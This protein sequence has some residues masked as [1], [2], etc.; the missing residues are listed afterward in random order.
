MRVVAF[1]VRNWPLKLAA[2]VLATL[3]YAGVVLSEN[4]QTFG[5]T[6]AIV[7]VRQPAN[8]VIVG[9]LPSVTNIRYVAPTDV[10]GRLTREGF[11]A[12][13]D[14][15]SANPTPENPYVNVRVDVQYADPRVRVLDYSPQV[16]P[17]QLDPLV[18]KSVPI[19]VDEGPV[20]SGIE[21]GAA[22][23]SSQSATVTGPD[24]VV[25]LVAAARARVLIQPSALNVDQD[26][27]LVAV[28]QLGNELGPANI[29]PSAVHVA[30]RVG[31][32]R[33]TKALPINP[34]VTGTPADGYQ[35]A[36]VAVAPNVATIA[37]DA[38]A[39]A[40]LA[41]VDSAP[42]SVSAASHD[43]TATVGL[44]LADGLEALSGESVTV[45]VR[46]R[47]VTGTRTFP[48]GIRTA[49]GRADRT[50]GLSVG[51]L[52]ATLGGTLAALDRVDA[53]TIVATVDVAG[54]GVGMHT[55]RLTVR[56]PS[57]TSL[58]ALSP[59]SIVVDVGAATPA[60]TPTPA[61]TASPSPSGP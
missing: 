3:L 59:A 14:L 57:G 34:V 32:E 20:P 53:S 26:V 39:L 18:S 51:Q 11:K 56:P 48:I 17:V 46:I 37:G 5:G 16:I 49:N 7:P 30:I 35:I 36:S 31:G 8:A 47:A 40:S 61:P 1:L 43:V 28:D 24:S 25:R 42:V 33:K 6:V 22:V 12:T 45:T 50:Y 41:R 23:L 52:N 54:L 2:V 44:A 38:A 55:V 27:P 29:D 9:N 19:E 60:P 13:I 10:A 21:V 4:V 58:V 15:G